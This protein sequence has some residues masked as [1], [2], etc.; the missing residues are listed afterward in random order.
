MWRLVKDE[1]VKI[2]VQKKSY[3]MAFGIV[4]LLLLILV[5]YVSP[6]SSYELVRGGGD[7][8]EIDKLRGY[9]DGW[10]FARLLL[11]STMVFL[12]PLVICTLAG[13]CIAGEIQEGSLK[14]L[15]ARSHTRTRVLM[16]KFLAVYLVSLAYLLLFVT[17]P[18]VVGLLFFGSSST[19]VMM[20]DSH[21][22]SMRVQIMSLGDAVGR[23]WLIV[24][25][26]ALAI[27]A[28]EAFAIFF[29]AL[30]NRMAAATVTT[31]SI[32]FITYVIAVLPFTVRLRPWL[33][34]YNFNDAY[35]FWL[36]PIPWS[37][38]AVNV[39]TLGWY[40]GF[41]LLLALIVFRAKD[42]T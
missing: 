21:I 11:A 35:V 20:F 42:I 30:F 32:Y 14:L 3:V 4:G 5:P 38:V 13:D 18:L 23:Y 41:F 25:Y 27:P 16:A 36:A 40:A 2:S 12:M 1:I 9:L 24:A 7:L 15:L 28:L 39:A 19:Q 31:M 37:R 34:S 29:S 33:L 22:H 17:L 26:Y 10:S 6:Q 8:L